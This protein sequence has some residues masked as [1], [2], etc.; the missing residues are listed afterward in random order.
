[1]RKGISRWELASGETWLHG[2]GGFQGST[3]LHIEGWGCPNSLRNISGLLGRFRSTK[4]RNK[5]WEPNAETWQSTSPKNHQKGKRRRERLMSSPSTP[6]LHL[7]RF[8]NLLAVPGGGSRGIVRW[9]NGTP[10]KDFWVAPS[11]SKR[12]KLFVLHVSFV[13]PHM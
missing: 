3:Y 7:G 2:L 6:P 10:P 1:M 9:G 5:T 12:S 13:W 8:G 11:L 4:P